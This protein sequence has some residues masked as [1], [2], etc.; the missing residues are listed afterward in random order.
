MLEK[1]I[2][3]DFKHLDDL[4]LLNQFIEEDRLCVAEFARTS[5][6]AHLQ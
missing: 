6:F 2:S 3:R 4:D 1:R 5:T